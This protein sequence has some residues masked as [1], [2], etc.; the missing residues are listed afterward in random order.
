MEVKVNILPKSEVEAVVSLSQSDFAPY[1]EKGAEEL[2]KNMKVEGFRPGKVPY[3]MIKAKVGEMAILEEAAHLAIH[4]TIDEVMEKHLADKNPIGNPQVEVTK[5]A[6][7]NPLEYKVTVAILPEV[8][9]GAYKELGIKE[10][11]VEIKDAEVKKSMD[12]LAE[13]KV[14]ESI[15][16]QEIKDGDK[17][18]ANL[19]LFLDKV[20]AEGGQA[21]DI[22]ILI[23]KEYFIPGF[24]KQLI[25]KK[26]DADLN[27]SLPY[28]ADHHMQHLAGKMVD[29]KVKI[30][31]VYHRERPVLDNE[32][33]KG[34]GF[35][36]LAELEAAA[37]KNLAHIQEHK[38]EQKTEIAMLDKIIDNAKFGD[39]PDLLVQNESQMML[40]ELEQQIAQYGGKFEDYLAS[41][42]K[43]KENLVMEMMPMAVKRV[44][45]AL[46][47]REIAVKEDLKISTED[48][49]HK[50]K[51]VKEQ[52]GNNP[53][54][55]KMT[56]EKGYRAYIGNI[57]ANQKV[58]KK[59]REW[60][61]S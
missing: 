42:K 29:F 20:P 25:G 21:Q 24:D 57:L 1:L 14:T 19:E 50:I 26:K 10:E 58:I 15:S 2:S 27:F 51:E 4:K 23:G 53:E 54:V 43:T 48:I 55:Q 41:I 38:N 31:E 47:L 33:A 44:K 35:G 36:T 12:D 5:L 18:I 32:F 7:E 37:K 22:T 40:G 8:T 61:I 52:Y 56:E 39:L 59:L 49:E 16:D 34:L 60:N 28:P 45:S 3:D 11:R 17:V 9:L 46:V 30:K 6:P 13:M